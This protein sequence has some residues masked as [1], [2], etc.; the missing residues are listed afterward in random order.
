M[1]KV[2]ISDV[3]AR[4]G[5]SEATVSRVL[6]R[7]GVVASGTRRVVE[8]AIR[9]LGYDRGGASQLVVVLSPDPE[10]IATLPNA[11]LPDRSDFKAYG[12]DMAGRVKAWTRA[13]GESERLRDEFAQWVDGRL[14]IE[15]EPLV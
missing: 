12:D 14:A 13:V 9:E 1:V 2:G 7:R 3:A 5:V 6:N 8:E 4:A 10:W 15:V 11:K